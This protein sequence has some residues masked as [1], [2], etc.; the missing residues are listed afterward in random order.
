MKWVAFMSLDTNKKFLGLGDISVLTLTS[1]FGIRWLAVA[2]GLG[3]SSIVFWIVGAILLG[4]PLAVM[5]G[6]L[7]KLF[8]EEGGIYAWTRRSLGE[9]SGFIVAWLYFINNVLYYPAVL[10]FL[11]T[12]FAYFLGKPALADNSHFIC[13]V[14]LVAFWLLVVISLY[15]LRVTKIISEYGG[16]IG[17]IIPAI[18]IIVLGFMFYYTT[19]ES[20]THF[21]LDTLFSGH[22]LSHSMANLTMIMFAM[23]GVEI[24]P[25]FAN[26]VKNPKRDI[27]FGLIIGASVMIALYIL[28]T[29]ALNIILSPGDIRKASGLMNA[30]QLVFLLFH[31]Q[32]MTRVIAFMLVFAELAVVSIWLV[33]PIV[34]FFKCTPKGL[35]PNWFHKTNK[36]NAPTNALLFVG[37]LVTIIL[38][39]TSL[40]PAVND[41][42][43]ILVLMS[44]LL[45]FIPYLFLLA[46]YVKNLQSISGNKFLHYFFVGSVFFSLVLGI[47]FSFQL[48]SNITTLSDKIFYESELFF[49]PIIS[50]L[51][52]YIIYHRWEKR[53]I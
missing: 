22:H 40:L 14:V 21:T 7:N 24:I 30:F 45:A 20:A 4:M 19:K 29:I 3:A 27:Y 51:V 35:L 43:Q 52:G 16:I 2:A 12:T 37:L 15:G 31:M 25:T 13:I 50:I 18:L 44:V 9:K 26:V 1:N 42:Y 38:L 39:T 5:S 10:I 49:G 28:G 11:A 8:P 34:M 48:P 47:V 46:A 33:A 6:H 32:W 41:V 53:M 23:T 36:N 17:S